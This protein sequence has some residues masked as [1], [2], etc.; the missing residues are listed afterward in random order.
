[1]ERRKAGKRCDYSR[2]PAIAGR[3]DLR[4]RD[5]VAGAEHS[6]KPAGLSIRVSRPALRAGMNAFAGSGAVVRGASSVT[7]TLDA[8]YSQLRTGH[9]VVIENAATGQLHAAAVTRFH[10]GP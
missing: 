10:C 2:K 5:A 7:L 8:L 3:R 1:M 9:S 6:C 4:R